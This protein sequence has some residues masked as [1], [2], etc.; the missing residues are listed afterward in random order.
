MAIDP[1]KLV[2]VLEVAEQ[3]SISRAAETLN[4][5]QP[6]LSRTIGEF[7]S[8]LGVRI[9]DRGPR[10]VTLTQ[11]GERLI[12]HAKVLRETLH[13]AEREIVET[14]AAEQAS[15]SIGIVPVHPID[16]LMQALVDLVEMRPDIRA[17][18]TTST[19]DQ[20][21]PLL[22]R[23]ELD[24]V[25]GPLAMTPMAGGYTETVIYYPDLGFY[26]GRAC[27]LS[28]RKKVSLNDLREM[29]WVLGPEGSFSRRR[30]DAFF[31][32]H[33]MDPPEVHIEF[34][35]I[36]ARRS[37]VLQSDF[38]SV[39]QRQHVLTEIQDGRIYPLPIEWRQDD[40]PIGVI[41]LSRSALSPA[42][43]DYVDAVRNA[44]EK[45]GV[46]GDGGTE[47]LQGQR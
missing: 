30:V 44:F 46:R 4:I 33:G 43:E 41:R 36:P 37:M 8:S 26:C 28:G 38:V 32:A 35:E 19:R 23:G 7:E 9:F 40:R 34:E 27:P 2:L 5:A 13:D 3:G 21:L 6:S 25:F 14:Q 31:R 39:F 15:I 11:E 42:A 29:K 47:A 22:D 12:A 1:R 18:F 17:R 45:S 10:G 16:P 24:L 20:L